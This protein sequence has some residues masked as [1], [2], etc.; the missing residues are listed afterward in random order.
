MEKSILSLSALGGTH[1]PAG[2]MPLPV[3]GKANEESYVSGEVE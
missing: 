3:M 2:K 1:L